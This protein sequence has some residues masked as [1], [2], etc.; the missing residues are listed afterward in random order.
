MA[1]KT[2]AKKSMEENLP[3]SY[4]IARNI[5]TMMRENK[6]S[7]DTIASLLGV[8]RA[9][10]WRRLTKSPYEITL[11]EVEILCQYWGITMAALTRPPLESAES[12]A[13]NGV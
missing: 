7:K 5:E 2:K 11:Q 13:L 4:Q 8:S 9:T 10:L 1:P 3:A 6:D 12:R